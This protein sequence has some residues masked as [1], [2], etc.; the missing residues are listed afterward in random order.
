M[1]LHTTSEVQ[2]EKNAIPNAKEDRDREIQLARKQG[3]DNSNDSV[4]S[5][6]CM[7]L[8]SHC[9]ILS[10]QANNN[11][12][13]ITTVFHLHA[14]LR[15]IKGF[16]VH[17]LTHIYFHFACLFAYFLV[18]TKCEHMGLRNGAGRDLIT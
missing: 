1:T 16:E 18:T 13:I 6:H 14:K 11:N 17:C 8:T 15:M 9:P 12:T 4:H 2:W 5:I 7:L 10:T 3:R